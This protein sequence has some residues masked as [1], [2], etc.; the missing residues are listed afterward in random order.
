MIMSAILVMKLVKHVIPI[1]LI[2]VLP[3]ILDSFLKMDIVLIL[4]TAVKALQKP[5]ENVKT[6]LTAQRPIA[7]PAQLAAPSALN[8]TLRVTP[9]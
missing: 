5:Q 4:E 8:A 9:Q 7:L 2:I 6:V 1:K 3:V